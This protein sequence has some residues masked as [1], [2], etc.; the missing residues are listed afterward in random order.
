MMDWKGYCHRCSKST[1]AHIMSSLNTQLICS[2]CY[3][4]EKKRP[5]YKKAKQAEIDAVRRG[6]YNFLGTGPRVL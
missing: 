4:A 5:D 1:N 3:D 2:E 6:D